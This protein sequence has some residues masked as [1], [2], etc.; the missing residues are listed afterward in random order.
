MFSE[1][2]KKHEE[3]KR[4]DKNGELIFDDLESQ[5]RSMRLSDDGKKEK[6][7]LL[8]R[9]KSKTINLSEY[10]SEM[11]TKN[12]KRKSIKKSDQ[13]PSTM[14]LN[15]G[16]SGMD[17]GKEAVSSQRSNSLESPGLAGTPGQS[18]LGLGIFEAAT[19]M[20]NIVDITTDST[21]MTF[22]NDKTKTLKSKE[23]KT[24]LGSASGPF[25]QM[26]EAQE[27]KKKSKNSF[28]DDD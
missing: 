24:S 9:R 20:C 7:E 28:E 17:K 14:S 2:K 1:H 4:N 8:N 27:M 11:E 19:M 15:V 13:K 21:T 10:M 25:S 12:P 22:K 23:S 3:A 5:T 26:K 6:S 16:K 18:N